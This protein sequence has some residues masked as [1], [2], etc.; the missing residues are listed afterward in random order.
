MNNSRPSGGGGGSLLSVAADRFFGLFRRKRSRSDEAAGFSPA[1]PYSK[2]SKLAV[3]ERP[4]S[5]V[6]EEDSDDVSSSDCY[7]SII[8]YYR[9][10]GR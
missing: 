10:L 2:R 6:T 7:F 1:E 9:C 4:L 5:T 3:F 8:V